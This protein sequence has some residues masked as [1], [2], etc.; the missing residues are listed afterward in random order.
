[1]LQTGFRYICVRCHAL[2]RKPRQEYYDDGHAGRMIDMCS[3]GCDIFEKIEN[4][5]CLHVVVEPRDGVLVFKEHHAKYCKCSVGTLWT[6][7]FSTECSPDFTLLASEKNKETLR[8]NKS[9]MT[10]VILKSTEEELRTEDAL[11][12]SFLRI[13][14]AT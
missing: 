2:H 9:G 4:I 1:M 3:C 13:P 8:C 5:P 11:G 6:G 10:I 7:D 14:S 12:S